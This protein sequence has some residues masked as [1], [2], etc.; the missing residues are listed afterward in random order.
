MFKRCIPRSEETCIRIT[1]EGRILDVP[2]NETVAAALLAAGYEHTGSS[3][4]SGC[5]RAPYCMIGACFECLVE[6]NGVPNQQ[7]CI[8]QVQ[9]GMIIRRQQGAVKLPH[10]VDI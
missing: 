8:T 1:V 3:P 5:K 2:H 7:A 4:I 10:A 6:I 9:D